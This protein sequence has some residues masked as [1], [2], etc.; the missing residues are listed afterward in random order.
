M[1][2]ALH[3]VC[4]HCH[5]VNRLPQEKLAAGGKCGRCKQPLFDGKPVEL[6][7][8]TFDRHISR[9]DI[10][11]LVDFWAPWCGPCKMMAPVFL[12]AAAQLQP[13]VQ[14]AKVNTEQEQTL[15]ARYGIR[16]IPTLALFKGGQE[17]DRVAGAMDLNNLLAWTR[18]H[19]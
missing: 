17:V 13:R 1:S 4:P 12:Q 11:L 10:P 16:S 6:T 5:S 8:A 14:L 19:L 15:A 2:D 3:I 18:Q 7:Q 9:S